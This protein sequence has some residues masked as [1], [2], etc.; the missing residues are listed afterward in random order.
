MKRIASVLLAAMLLALCVPAFAAEEEAPAFRPV[1][2]AVS[3][4][5]DAVR[6]LQGYTFTYD[7]DSADPAQIDLTDSSQVYTYTYDE[8][9]RMLTQVQDTGFGFVYTTSYTYDEDGQLAQEDLETS[10]NG[11]V[12]SAST[13]VY[14]YT[15]SGKIAGLVYDSKYTYDGAEH[16]DH[17]E[18]A[19]EYDEQDRTIRSSS[20]FST[21]GGEP[22][23]YE[24]TYTYDEQGRCTTDA[25]A[26]VSYDEQ[27]RMAQQEV[28]DPGVQVGTTTYTYAPFFKIQCFSGTE[29]D[30]SV[31]ASY[32]INYVWGDIVQMLAMVDS[33]AELG[34]DENGLLTDVTFG[35]GSSI[36]IAYE[37]IG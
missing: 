32:Q 25:G 3:S 34:Y 9:G 11:E 13:S 8:A 22:T 7:G 16:Q 2:I 28:N 6:I 23:S 15:E 4:A 36:Q 24:L 14:T 10:N 18:V 30:E 20:T 19:Y 21:D 31:E 29:F 1:S 33:T 35:D 26:V 12:T 37:P 5:S 27:G 17:E